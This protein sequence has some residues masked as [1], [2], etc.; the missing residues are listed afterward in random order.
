M[1]SNTVGLPVTLTRKHNQ[2]DPAEVF[3]QLPLAQLFPVNPVRTLHGSFWPQHSARP[4]GRG[5]KQLRVLYDTWSTAPTLSCTPAIQSRINIFQIPALTSGIFV[6]RVSLL[7]NKYNT[8][9][10]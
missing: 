1:L 4:W 8:I 7:K 10:I 6:S 3:E 9:S 5:R 2:N